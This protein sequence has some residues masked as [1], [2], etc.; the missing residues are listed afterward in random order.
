LQWLL[1]QLVNVVQLHYQSLVS[2]L[3]LED[4][5]SQVCQRGQNRALITFLMQT[6]RR[7]L[8]TN[9]YCV[10]GL[11]KAAWEGPQSAS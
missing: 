10:A 4:V 7:L 8:N 3:N 11:A 9:T 6:R 1:Y 2:N 5:E